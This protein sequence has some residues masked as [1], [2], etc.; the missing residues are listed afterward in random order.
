VFVGLY[1]WLAPDGEGDPRG[2]LRRRSAA[3]ST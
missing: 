3:G 1:R 2:G